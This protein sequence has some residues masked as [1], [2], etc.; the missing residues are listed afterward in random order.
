MKF[1]FILE[2]DTLPEAQRKITYQFEQDDL[3][4]ILDEFSDFIR[5][6]GFVPDGHLQFVNYESSDLECASG[7]LITLK[8]DDF[9]KGPKSLSEVKHNAI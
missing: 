8:A 4:M 3:D 5:G 2:D 1:T 6:C 9:L 7:P